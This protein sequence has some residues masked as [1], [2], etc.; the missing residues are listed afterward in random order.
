[1]GC[2][3]DLG[4]KYDRIFSTKRQTKSYLLMSPG[5]YS[6]GEYKDNIVAQRLRIDDDL[7]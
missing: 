5:K 7:V 1:M 4:R 3:Q 2:L 6:F